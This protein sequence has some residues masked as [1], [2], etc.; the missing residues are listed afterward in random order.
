MNGKSKVDDSYKVTPYKRKHSSTS[1]EP[2]PSVA[3]IQKKQ[4]IHIMNAS[5][6]DSSFSADQADPAF[7]T[8]VLPA[9]LQYKV[10]SLGHTFKGPSVVASGGSGP[11]LT[12]VS[13]T[14]P[15]TAPGAFPIHIPQYTGISSTPSRDDTSSISDTD[16]MRIAKAVKSLMADEITKLVDLKLQ[17]V[18]QCVH[19]LADENIKLHQKV[20]ELEMYS[21]RDCVRIFGVEET[22]TDTDAV[23]VEIADK[24]EVPLKKEDIAVSHRVGKPPK[25]AEDRPRA[26]IARIKKYDTRHDLIRES[27]NL[28]KV[29]G[30]EGYSVNQELTKTRAKLAY[31]CRSLVRQEFAKSTFVWDGKIFIVD[32]K[33]KK[34]KVLCL[35]DLLEVRKNLGCPVVA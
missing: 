5:V 29:K 16:V 11:M 15:G 22:K 19:M 14:V 6:S 31:E 2:S 28:H 18:I 25:S 35:N 30:M 33:E 8:N 27:K 34:H 13:A 32:K 23:V 24:L 3:H 10:A 9:S 1:S 12:P 17:P 4:S 26:I 7:F 20:D 21:R